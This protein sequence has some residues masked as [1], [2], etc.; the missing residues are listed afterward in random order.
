[1]L[2][3]RLKTVLSAILVSTID[4]MEPSIKKDVYLRVLKNSIF[5]FHVFNID[6][7]R[8][9]LYKGFNLHLIW[10]WFG[11]QDIEPQTRRR[12]DCS[13][14]SVSLKRVFPNVLAFVVFAWFYKSIFEIWK[15]LLIHKIYHYVST[16]AF[17]NILFCCFTVFFSLKKMHFF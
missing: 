15:L 17:C 1:M 11:L 13:L 10:L 14:R 6:I 2:R 4:H 7:T 12:A 3:L 9:M 5:L 8:N 16:W